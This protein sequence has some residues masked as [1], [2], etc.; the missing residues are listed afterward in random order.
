MPHPMEDESETVS[1]EPIS[2]KDLLVEIKDT[3][4]LLIDLAYS[5]LI[6]S[7]EDIAR[8]VLDLEEKMDVLQMRSRMSLLLAARTTQDA[9][10]LAPVLGVIA[11]AE[12]ISDA[13][14]DIAKVVLEDIG[15]PKQLRAGLPEAVETVSQG[16]VSS[17]SALAG[18]TLGEI[19][20]ERETGV[21]VI[22]IHRHDEWVM[23]PGRDDTVQA[24]DRLIIRGPKPNLSKVYERMTGETYTEPDIEEDV[25]GPDF[26]RAINSIVLMKN[27]S[28][29]AVD[30]AYSSVLFDNES[31]AEE[32]RNLEVEMDGLRSRYEAWILQSAGEIDDPVSLR[33]MLHLGVATESISDAAIEISEGILRDIDVHPVTKLAVQES[34]EVMVRVRVD[35]TSDLAGKT[36][37]AGVLETTPSISILATR[38]PGEGWM[39][40]GEGS[41]ELQPDDVLIAKGRSSVMQ[42]FAQEESATS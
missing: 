8:E 20:L 19:D 21:R 38:R 5:A 28:E 2:V 39:L 27:L 29:L 6:H 40:M 9:E 18:Q 14:G 12:K 33:G 41:M 36:V 13:T 4:E 25:S 34:D 11:G 23:N 10:E 7:N 16:S 32:V 31:L 37:S 3:S 1:Y 35:E 26:E 30:L 15:F 42:E 17:E 22:A 24:D